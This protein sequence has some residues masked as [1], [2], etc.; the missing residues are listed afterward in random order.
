MTMDRK[1][2]TQKGAQ[3]NKTLEIATKDFQH[4]ET[5]GTVSKHSKC[6]SAPCKKRFLNISWVV[7]FR[8]KYV[9]ILEQ[10]ENSTKHVMLLVF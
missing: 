4:S 10:E 3:P 2:V 9:F 1:F 7:N 5:V 6:I 8:L